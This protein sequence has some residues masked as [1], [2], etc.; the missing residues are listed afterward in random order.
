MRLRRR[1]RSRLPQRKR[2]DPQDL[3]TEIEI[4]SPFSIQAFCDNVAAHRGRPLRLE[5]VEGISGSNDELCGLWIELENSD[6]IFYEASTS[7]LHRDHI[8][9]HEISHML[10]GH[11][12][13]NDVTPSVPSALFTG[14]APQT[15]RSVLARANFDTPQEREAEQLATR[16]AK[17]AELPAA[18]ARPAELHRIDVALRSE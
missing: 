1:L 5:A 8:V 15:V 3:L 6:C 10:L 9:L 11:S 17:L 12:S 14:I 18:P 16:I 13:V 7:P 2:R 4:P